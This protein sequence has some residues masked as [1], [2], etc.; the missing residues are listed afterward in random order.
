MGW[1][2]S[3][4]VHLTEWVRSSLCH[5][6]FVESRPMAAHDTDAEIEELHDMTGTTAREGRTRR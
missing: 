6:V 5:N 3:P 4:F 2:C 1:D